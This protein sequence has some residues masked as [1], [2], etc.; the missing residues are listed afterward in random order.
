M[1]QE[2]GTQKKDRRLDVIFLLLMMFL[3][4]TLLMHIP[5]K[6]SLSHQLPPAIC[7]KCY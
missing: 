6:G 3:S 1:K 5:T 4:F 2:P 7:L